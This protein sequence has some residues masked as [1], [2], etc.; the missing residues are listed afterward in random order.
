MS[1]ATIRPARIEDVPAA[2]RLAAA[3][4]RQHHAFDPD[5]F[6][7]VEPVEEGYAR[8]LSTQVDREGVVLL[9]A[10]L[11]GTV[12]GYLLGGLEGRDW[13][14]L[15][16]DCGMIHDV[17][18]DASARGRGIGTA[19]VEEAVAR[20]VAMGVPRVVLSTA[21]PNEAARRLFA[22]LGFRETMV[23]MTREAGGSHHSG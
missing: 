1:P 21:W 23:E 19:I 2:S 14:L 13:M 9:V 16:D 8:F 4:V 12:V 17:Y 18:V 11:D 5:R 15:L 7:L 3:L 6:M 20:L 22:K 10:E